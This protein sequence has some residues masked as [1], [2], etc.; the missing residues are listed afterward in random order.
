[1][2]KG[3]FLVLFLALVP[4]VLAQDGV[5]ASAFSLIFGTAGRPGQ[6]IVLKVGLWLALIFVLFQGAQKIFKSKDEHGNE[7]PNKKIAIA[8]SIVIS[9]IAVRFMPIGVLE[10][11]GAVTW[12]AALI[13][14]PYT[15]V[16][17]VTDNKWA[18]AIVTGIVVLLATFAFSRFGTPYL[19]PFFRGSEFL[20]DVYY[21]I[22]PQ[23]WLLPV[24]F[25]GVLLI[26]LFILFAGKGIPS[27]RG[28][29]ATTPSGPGLFKRA[30]GGLGKA[31]ASPFKALGGAL[32]GTG[33][34]LGA[35]ARGAGA[36]AKGAG[37]LAGQ[38]LGGAAKG[39][40][41]AAQGLGA[42]AGGLAKGAG[43]L[44]GSALGKGV[45]AAGRGL[46]QL[47]SWLRNKFRRKPKHPKDQPPSGQP[48]TGQPKEPKKPY[49]GPGLFRKAANL[50]RA[51]KKQP[52]PATPKE[53]P[54]YAPEYPQ[55]MKP[56]RKIPWWQFRKR[57][58]A[59]NMDIAKRGE[60]EEIFAKQ[61]IHIEKPI[62]LTRRKQPLKQRSPE[63]I[64][65]KIKE[66]EAKLATFR[67]PRE[68]ARRRAALESYKRMRKK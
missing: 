35:A 4:T 31:I 21:L 1:M 23:Y 11:L 24:L 68:V 19:F 20:S 59:R 53:I 41:A 48:P 42:G 67:N 55:I 58:K 14:I 9:I 33:R 38:A 15:L 62:P 26:L 17:F 47:G 61:P 37:Q 57:R 43:E 30:L 50:F 5:F 44:A 66:H 60:A 64:E 8:F 52:T 3:I 7:R 27:V 45:P 18:K 2:K 54:T 51:G 29:G 65:A 32:K 22:S 28:G 40:G 46:G 6:D 34:G 12:I 16:G 49:Q 13:L 36:V 10:T 63:K 56:E 39:V 25:A